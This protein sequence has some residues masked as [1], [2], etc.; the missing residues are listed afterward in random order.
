MENGYPST[1]TKIM[2]LYVNMKQL[3]AIGGIGESGETAPRDVDQ[4]AKQGQEVA[5]TLLLMWMDPAQGKSLRLR[6]VIISVHQVKSLEDFNCNECFEL[7]NTFKSVDGNW[8]EWREWGAC[9]KKCG[10][11]QRT[12]TRGCN[13]PAPAYGGSACTGDNVQTQGFILSI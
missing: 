6:I 8:G 9:S 3:K 10:P 12:R 13:N 11:G 1:K 7:S 2:P 4:A 5:I